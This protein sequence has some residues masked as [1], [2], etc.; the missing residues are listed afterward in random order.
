MRLYASGVRSGILLPACTRGSVLPVSASYASSSVLTS[1][2]L[3]PASWP[4]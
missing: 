3:I 4:F 1:W 2:T